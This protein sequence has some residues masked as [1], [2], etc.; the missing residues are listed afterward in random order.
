MSVNAAIQNGF[1]PF[2]FD[3]LVKPLLIY[4]QAYDK[5]EKEYFDL[6]EQTETW[7][8][9]ATRTQNPEAYAMYKKY[10]NDLSYVADDFS[11]G[12]TSANRKA[13]LKMK[14]RYAKE[15][16][17]IETASNAMKEANAYRDNVLARDSSAIFRV[18]RYD[19]ID[20]FLHGKT[21]DNSYVS[22]DKILARTSARAE[23]VGRAMFSDPKFQLVLGKQKY[24]MMQANGA[25]PEQLFAAIS[26]DPDAIPF[27]TKIYDEQWSAVDGD[28]FN[29]QGQAQIRDAITTG[30][31]AALAKPTYNYVENGEYVNNAQ[32]QSL[33][34]QRRQ[35]A[36]SEANQRS[37]QETRDIASGRAPMS[38]NADGSG[39]FSDGT[40]TWKGT[41]N[42]DG[43][44]VETKDS[45][46]IIPS[47]SSSN[48]NS[49]TNT[50]GDSWQDM[51]N[52]G[53]RTGE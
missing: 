38:I 52:A 24:Q 33:E 42:A 5:T 14:R 49:N 43:Q 20:S 9:I 47:R 12:M 27:L 34:L 3:E 44:W 11:R 7:A 10:S 1:R 19:S 26:H 35:V 46:K 29:S 31:Y 45:R 37:M 22:G 32:G 30:M 28:S 13:L 4:Q 40:W 15:I 51:V 16:K 53:I 41:K 36:V 23:A 18:G 39:N 8:D 2:S 21:A 17:P 25:T 48:T 50:T 6:A